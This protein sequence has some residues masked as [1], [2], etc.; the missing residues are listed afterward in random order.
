MS[1]KRETG[2][3]TELCASVIQ[4][5]L[6][7]GVILHPV[8]KESLAFFLRLPTPEIKMGYLDHLLKLA[9]HH[10]THISRVFQILMM[11]NVS[12]EV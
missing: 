4:E 12:L 2:R 10:L 5:E 1:P 7:E 8:V 11:I 3:V 6:G 9:T